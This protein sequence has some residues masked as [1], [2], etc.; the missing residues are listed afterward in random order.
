MN[1]VVDQHG[2]A[3]RDSYVIGIPN[4]IVGEGYWGTQ[5]ISQDCV[6]TVAKDAHLNFRTPIYSDVLI[7]VIDSTRLEHHADIVEGFDLISN[8]GNSATVL[9]VNKCYAEQLRKTLNGFICNMNTVTEIQTNGAALSYFEHDLI[10]ACISAFVPSNDIPSKPVSQKVHRYIVDA[11]TSLILSVPTCPPTISEL[12]EKLHISR[13]TLHYAFVKM[14]GVNPVT[15]IRVIRLNRVRRELLR[16]KRSGANIKEI[17]AT[18][19]FWHMG[20]FAKY[21]LELFGEHPSETIRKN[22]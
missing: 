13:R 7:A 21:Y 18:W 20:M 15:Y 3:R 22:S 14:M 1:Q 16:A 9:H 10:T 12:C 8:F 6:L 5:S 17:A 11:A 19:G 2:V 4:K